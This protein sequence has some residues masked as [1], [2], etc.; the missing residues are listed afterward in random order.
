MELVGSY[1]GRT[2]LTQTGMI[3]IAL[4]ESAT[5][6]KVNIYAVDDT[7]TPALVQVLTANIVG[8][9]AILWPNPEVELD[10][11]LNGLFEV[12]PDAVPAAPTSGTNKNVVQIPATE[13]VTYSNGA[14]DVTGTKI[15]LTANATIVATAK[16]GYEIA[17]GAV[18]SWDL[19][20]T[21]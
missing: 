13:G 3:S 20:Y 12:T 9:R 15:T 19:V 1:S 4:D 14:T 2:Y 17:A 8:D 11:N 21:A 16:T 5:A 7:N 6:V 10:T 18:T